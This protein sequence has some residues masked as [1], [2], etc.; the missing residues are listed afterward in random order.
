[1]GS[2]GEIARNIM[3][4][5]APQDE[6][7]L[8]ELPRNVGSL[9]A[10]LAADAGRVDVCGR[11]PYIGRARWQKEEPNVPAVRKTERIGARVRPADKAFIEEAAEHI[12]VSVADFLV[13]SARERAEEIIQ[14]R[15]QMILTSRDQ[16]AFVGALLN[17]PSPNEVLK[18]AVDVFRSSVEH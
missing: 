16:Q 6:D 11:W 7:R 3:Q 13:S 15:D 18:A 4:S 14:R 10:K 5:L 12:G 2:F 8:G 1:M 9:V 17:P